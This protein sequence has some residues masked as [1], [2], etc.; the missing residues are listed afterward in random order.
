MLDSQNP[1][2]EYRWE[3]P[4]TNCK[5]FLLQYTSEGYEDKIAEHR[6]YHLQKMK[7]ERE[8]RQ[9]NTNWPF[10]KEEP[11]RDLNKLVLTLYDLTQFELH[12]IKVDE[13]CIIDGYSG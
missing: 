12:Y 7:E 5:F 13:D 10:K 3:C 4:Y 1:I 11:K 6:A 2:G 9:K 8:E